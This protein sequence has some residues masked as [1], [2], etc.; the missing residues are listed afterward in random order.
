MELIFTGRRF[1]VVAGTFS[2]VSHPD[3]T[4]PPWG[5]EVT[6][7]DDA[8]RFAD[9]GQPGRLFVSGERIVFADRAGRPRP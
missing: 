1:S 4:Q 5:T 8:C 2:F 7:A 3:E 6:A 9:P